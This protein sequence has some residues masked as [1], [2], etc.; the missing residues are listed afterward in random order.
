MDKLYL[1]IFILLVIS[2]LYISTKQVNIEGF[3]PNI[4][5]DMGFMVKNGISF[6]RKIDNI[7][8]NLKENTKFIKLMKKEY[9]ERRRNAIVMKNAGES[10]SN[11]MINKQKAELSKN[12]GISQTELDNLIKN[13]K[14]PTPAQA[15]K[16]NMRNLQLLM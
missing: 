10:K 1:I 15:K 16:S 4:N 11:D 14:E 6:I 9:E 8:R 12:M 5:M 3:N 7:E 2:F 13:P